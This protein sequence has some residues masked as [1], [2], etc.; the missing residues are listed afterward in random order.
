MTDA[1]GT[2]PAL[3]S[4]ALAVTAAAGPPAEGT[5]AVA[6][7]AGETGTGAGPADF[8]AL[9]RDLQAPAGQAAPP[10]GASSKLATRPDAAA[11]LGTTTLTDNETVLSMLMDP[12]DAAAVAGLAGEDGPGGKICG[13]DLPDSGKDLPSPDDQAL[14]A[15]LPGIDPGL[16]NPVIALPV[17]EPTVAAYDPAMTIDPD[18]AAAAASISGTARQALPVPDNKPEAANDTPAAHAA[19]T[20]DGLAPML[21]ADAIT[22]HGGVSASSTPSDAPGGIHRSLEAMLADPAR[23]VAIRADHGTDSASLALAQ[24]PGVT[25]STVAQLTASG[26]TATL[27]DNLPTLQPG[28][29]P[30]AWSRALGERL[31]MMADKG[32]QSATLRLQPEHLGPMEIRISVS[33]DGATKVLFSAHHGQT[34]DALEG[35][36]PRLRELFAEQGLSLAQANVD[37]GRSGSFAQR[38]FAGEGNSPQP[39]DKEP[40]TTAAADEPRRWVPLRHPT[41]RLDVMA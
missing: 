40:A 31:L 1:V 37:A 23:A 19:D 30:E 9:L 29:N 14:L 34:R 6:A 16:A 21:A 33:E 7:D 10:V 41:Q 12:A 13:E 38:G 26:M 4:L 36:I 3:A 39:W 32:L 18:A 17:Q 27:P 8:D 24:G 35:A 20:V 15:G 25:G 2:N 5:A 22:A 28:G 11:A